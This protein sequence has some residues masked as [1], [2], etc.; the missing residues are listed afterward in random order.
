MKCAIM[1]PH[2]LPW[3]GYFN[4][5]ASVDIF[6][7]LDDVQF[8]K[9]SWQT[10]NRIL[11]DGNVHTLSV[12][13]KRGPLAQQI[14]EVMTN[15]DH[16]NWRERHLK[17]L[18]NAYRKTLSGREIIDLLREL[19]GR[20]RPVH[21]ADLNTNIV[22]AF[23][24]EIG[25]QAMFL[26][27]SELTIRSQDRTGRLIEICEL[28]GATSYLAPVGSAEYLKKDNFSSRTSTKVEYQQFSCA[29]YPQIGVHEFQSHLS[30]VDLCANVGFDR[31]KDLIVLGK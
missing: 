1:Q 20:A 7:F 30:I 24:K 31:A 29:M 12:P 6:V 4:L 18:E 27:T 11:L 14:R 13:I 23:S 22:K 16:R 25:L 5:V 26:K 21:L 10:R 17:T 15:E 19:F 9:Q 3:S 8:E 28:L 2:F